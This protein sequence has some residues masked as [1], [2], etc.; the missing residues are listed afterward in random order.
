[1][2]ELPF[3]VSILVHPLTREQVK[4]PPLHSMK[5]VPAKQNAWFTAR[6]RFT[7]FSPGILS[8]NIFILL[9]EITRF[10][11]HG[12]VLH[13]HSTCLPYPSGATKSP[14]NTQASVWLSSSKFRS[15]VTDEFYHL[16]LGYSSTAPTLSLEDRKKI[17]AHVEHILKS[18]KEAAKAPR[19]WSRFYVSHISRPGYVMYRR[20]P[21]VRCRWENTIHYDV[22]MSELSQ[23]SLC[24]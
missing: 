11:M 17:G 3:L 19:D 4:F 18:E 22:P 24:D 15:V 21:S 7:M 13:S 5:F 16:E 14:C 2:T 10:E 8:A 1:M 12:L 23:S 9:S 6:V 20:R